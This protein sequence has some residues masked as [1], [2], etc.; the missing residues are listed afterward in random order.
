M[1][2]KQGEWTVLAML[3]W[4]T[5]YFEKKEI[6]APRHS[7]EWLLADILH[8]KRLD[9]YLSYNRPLASS[10]LEQ[11]RPL[12]KRRAKH[13]PLQ[14]ITGSSEFMNVQI[15]V[16]SGVLIPRIETEQLTE[17]ILDEHHESPALSVLDIGTGSGCIAVALKKKHPSWEVTATDISEEALRVAHKNAHQNEVE[18]VLKKHDI[19][20]QGGEAFPTPFDAIISNPPYILP[21]REKAL[22]PQVKSYEPHRALFCDEPEKIYQNIM[23]FAAKYLKKK[24]ML[25]LE[26][27]AELSN[28]IISLFDTEKWDYSLLKDYNK[29]PRFIKAQKLI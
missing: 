2:T 23:D 6:P 28:T 24:G 12:I 21:A 5:N 9:L 29:K 13:E 17:I 15:T 4:G 11:L 26:I 19:N 7:I 27:N 8:V 22:E 18:I 20:Q 25:Y 1:K 16:N 3:K 14:Y 10:E